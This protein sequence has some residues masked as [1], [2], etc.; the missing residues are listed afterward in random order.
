MTR[1]KKGVRKKEEIEMKGGNLGIKKNV[2]VAAH[3]NQKRVSL[4]RA[5]ERCASCGKKKA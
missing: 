1:C 5:S 3:K 2:D 4:W